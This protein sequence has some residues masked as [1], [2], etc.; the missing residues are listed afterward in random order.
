MATHSRRS[1]TRR[2]KRTQIVWV[3]LIAAMTGVGALLLLVQGRPLPRLNGLSLP[4]LVAPTGAGE[5]FLRTRTPLD[6]ERWTGIVIH[7]SGASYGS[8][9]SIAAE[10]EAMNLRGLGHHF[11]IGNGFGMDDAEIHVGYRWLDQLPG[12]HVGGQAGEHHNRHSISI[13]LVGDGNRRSFTDAQ[14]RRL[15]DLVDALRREF[16]LA[17]EDVLLHSQI[18]ETSDPGELFP[19]S[20]FYDL[21]KAR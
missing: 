7:H 12:A 21:I 6:H 19:A 11:I 4:A 8:P 20:E 3:S 18:N 16:A 15:I 14:M 1:T 5:A 13:C 2:P 17:P 10:H 9:A